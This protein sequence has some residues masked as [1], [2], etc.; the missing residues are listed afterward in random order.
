[1]Q[2]IL[3]LYVTVV[4]MVFFLTGFLLSC[5]AYVPIWH[6]WFIVVCCLIDCPEMDCC[7]LFDWLPWDGLLL[8]AWLIDC[9]EMDCWLL[10]VAVCCL[11]MVDVYMAWLIPVCSWLLQLIDWLMAVCRLVSNF[12]IASSWSYATDLALFFFLNFFVIMSYVDIIFFFWYYCCLVL[13]IML[14]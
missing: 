10:F 8:V 1:M 2:R 11:E 14:F 3:F 7:L 6:N 4:L 5:F 9:L 12:G 13:G